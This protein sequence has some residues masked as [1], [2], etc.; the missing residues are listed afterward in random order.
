MTRASLIV[1][2]WLAGAPALADPREDCQARK[3]SWLIEGAAEG[4]R[5]AGQREGL[6]TLRFPGGQTHETATFAG[7]RLEGPFVRYHA[8]CQVAERGAFLAGE[9]NGAWTQWTEAGIKTG[10]GTYAHN[11]REGTWTYYD[12]KEGH[13]EIQGPFVADRAEG[14]FTEWFANGNKWRTFD[15]K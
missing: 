12:A 10:E 5:D 4:C 2:V 3:G 9:R 1:I 14:T 11:L 6:W 8:N 13:K 7:G 15:M